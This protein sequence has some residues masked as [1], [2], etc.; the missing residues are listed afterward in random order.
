M[1]IFGWI[2]IIGLGMILAAKTAILIIDLGVI[3]V[4]AT[5]IWIASNFV[6]KL[7]PTRKEQ[8]EKN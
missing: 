8:V 6:N 2:S 5:P 1:S 3:T 4:A 7:F